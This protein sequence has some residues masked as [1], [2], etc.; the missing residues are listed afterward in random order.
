MLFKNYINDTPFGSFAD[1]KFP[2]LKI[3][4]FSRYI[5]AFAIFLILPLVFVQ[6]LEPQL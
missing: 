2:S 1:N 3:K 4:A 5:Y 6:S